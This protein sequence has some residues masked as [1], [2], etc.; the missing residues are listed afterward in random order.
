MI[1]QEIDY[2]VKN[3]DVLHLDDFIFRRSMIG[4]LGRVTKEGLAELAEITAEAL[5]WDEQKK[6]E[7][8]DRVIGILKTKHQMNFNQFIGGE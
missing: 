6:I 5:D 8:I 2:I 3:E 7:E 4:K 1:E